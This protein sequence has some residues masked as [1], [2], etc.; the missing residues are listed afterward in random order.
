MAGVTGLAWGAARSP[1]GH[2]AGKS[3]IIR[4]KVVILWV[5]PGNLQG[6]AIK[7]ADLWRLI[8]S[9]SLAEARKG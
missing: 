7:T 5:V 9:C 6:V 8:F 3:R 4:W 1:G 2:G